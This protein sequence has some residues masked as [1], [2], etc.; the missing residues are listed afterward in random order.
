MNKEFK[1]NNEEISLSC[2]SESF[3]Y[4]GKVK[5]SLM[6]D[7]VKYFTKVF[8]NHGRWPLFYFFNLCLA[9]DYGQAEEFRPRFINLFDFGLS[10]QEIKP[11]VIED[12]SQTQS[13]KMTTWFNA[14]NNVSL[15]SY[16]MMSKPD[17]IV[18]GG[19]AAEE[20]GSSKITYKFTIPFTQIQTKTNQA[21]EGFALYSK[22][23]KNSVTDPKNLD[24]LANPAAFFFLTDENGYVTNLLQDLSNINLGDEYNLYI[25]WIL[26]VRN[27]KTNPAEE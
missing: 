13:G 10:N 1:E 20:I 7:N 14:Q 3:Y 2:P 9:G 5:I 21:I 12:G 6:R 19:T 23:T 11:P 17:V 25:E 16:P 22:Q 27:P 4:T 18:A 15:I 24:N 26:T 8:Y